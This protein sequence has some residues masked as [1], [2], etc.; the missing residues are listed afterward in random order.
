MSLNRDAALRELLATLAPPMLLAA[1]E[2]RAG[3]TGVAGA[4][5]ALRG[6]RLR[7]GRAAS[8]FHFGTSAPNMATT[9]SGPFGPRETTSPQPQPWSITAGVRTI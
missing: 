6:L 8:G 5:F 3:V 2:L 1:A 7:C 9:A 4:A